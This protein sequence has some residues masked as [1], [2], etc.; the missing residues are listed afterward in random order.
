MT[1]FAGLDVSDKATHVCVVDGEGTVVRRE[2]VASD[3][4][5]LAKWLKQRCVGLV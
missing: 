3:P 2:V 5:V 4:A 1:I